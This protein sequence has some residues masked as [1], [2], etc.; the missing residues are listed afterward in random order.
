MQ[1]EEV[2]LPHPSPV[3]PATAADLPGA[4][5]QGCN[6]INEPVVGTVAGGGLEQGVQGQ[7]DGWTWVFEGM[8]RDG[9]TDRRTDSRGGWM[10][11][12]G[13]MGVNN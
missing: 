7:T 3:P 1:P 12:N 10:E 9:W 8:E 6:I 13:W 5:R 4:S 11:M 2:L